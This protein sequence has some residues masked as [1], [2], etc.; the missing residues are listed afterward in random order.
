[1][2][3]LDVSETIF[4]YSLREKT[5]R[6]YSS[7]EEETYSILEED[8]GVFLSLLESLEDHEEGEE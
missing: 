8:D 2:N 5:S 1:M 6:D 3:H 7:L 4:K